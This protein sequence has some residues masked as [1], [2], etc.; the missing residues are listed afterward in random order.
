LTK[1]IGR[2]ISPRFGK[3]AGTDEMRGQRVMVRPL[4]INHRCP[5]QTKDVQPPAAL[6]SPLD[7]RPVGRPRQALNFLIP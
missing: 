4:W 1:Q 7:V 5:R 2:T 6:R 3:L